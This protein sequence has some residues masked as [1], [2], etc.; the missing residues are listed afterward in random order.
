MARC[1]TPDVEHPIQCHV[2]EMTFSNFCFFL[3]G[4]EP[5]LI[6]ISRNVFIVLFRSKWDISV[7]A[8][9]FGIG[10]LGSATNE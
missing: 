4:N 1:A 2:G 6:D 8:G 10:C 7:Q 3:G 9:G 5:H